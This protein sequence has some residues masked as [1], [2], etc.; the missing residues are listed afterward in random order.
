[1]NLWPLCLLLQ[2]R[3]FS[4]ISFNFSFDLLVTCLFSLF[5]NSEVNNGPKNV[6]LS[7]NPR[8]IDTRMDE[9][10]PAK[11]SRFRI[12]PGK[13]NAKVSIFFFHVFLFP[14]PI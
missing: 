8:Y 14:P 7:R 3:H 10:Y 2:S 12:L 13:E 4:C 9:L 6:Q 1:M 11:K 5:H